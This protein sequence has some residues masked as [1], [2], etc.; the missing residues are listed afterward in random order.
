M[1]SSN[2][3]QETTHGVIVAVSPEYLTDHSDPDQSRYVWA[4][5]VRI[6]NCGAT[7]VQLLYRHWSIA[8]GIGGKH[9]VVGDGVLGEQP[10]LAPGESYTYSSGTPLVTATGFMSGRFHM[11]SAGGERFDIEVPAFSLDA[12]ERPS[13]L[14]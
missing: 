3:Y 13:A 2:V 6:E 5:H 14:H 12:F 11:I 8:D 9:D 10:T 7:P 1:I 4:Y